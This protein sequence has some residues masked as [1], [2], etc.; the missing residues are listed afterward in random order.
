MTEQYC[1]CKKH[2]IRIFQPEALHQHGD[3]PKDSA[4]VTEYDM[5]LISISSAINSLN[6]CLRK[7]VPRDIYLVIAPLLVVQIIKLIRTT[8]AIRPELVLKCNRLLDV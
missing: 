6:I 3:S 1:G 4:L 5:P 7:V 8:A 2:K